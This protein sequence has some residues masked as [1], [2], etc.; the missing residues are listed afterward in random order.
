MIRCIQKVTENPMPSEKDLD[1]LCKLLN[2]VG[3]KLDKEKSE[4]IIEMVK[5]IYARIDELLEKIPSGR[6]K[7]LLMDVIDIRKNGWKGLDVDPEKK[8][9]EAKKSQNTLKP[10]K[11]ELK[12]TTKKS[13]KT[14]TEPINKNRINEWEK[15]G[16]LN[17]LS[18]NKN[19]SETK[20]Y[21][22]RKP[23][24]L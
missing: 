7:F 8:P 9:R 2:T 13:I 24:G 23:R 6:N 3:E 4:D 11:R 14:L 15:A 22:K 19:G 1:V 16:L 20:K 5:S 18:N 10:T 12:K 17:V 21:S